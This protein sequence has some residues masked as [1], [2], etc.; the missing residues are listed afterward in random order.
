[1]A[2]CHTHHKTFL[3]NGFNNFYTALDVTVAEEDS[4]IPVIELFCSLACIL[5]EFTNTSTLPSHGLVSSSILGTKDLNG[6]IVDH[7]ERGRQV[8]LLDSLAVKG[9]P[10]IRPSKLQ[11][12]TDS[13]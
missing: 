11:S 2:K 5:G 4:N 12:V 9:E 3:V 13:Q 7:V 1:L 10:D 6:I 8:R